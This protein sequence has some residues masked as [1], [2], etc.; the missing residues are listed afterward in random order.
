MVEYAVKHNLFEYIGDFT[1][2][3]NDTKY[4]SKLVS[5]QTG[6]TLLLDIIQ[7]FILSVSITGCVLVR[8]FAARPPLSHILMQGGRIAMEYPHHSRVIISLLQAVKHLRLIPF[9]NYE[10][11]TDALTFDSE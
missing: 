11:D 4:I 1:R 3:F 10:T 8:G 9:P 2:A 6:N 5:F 7:R